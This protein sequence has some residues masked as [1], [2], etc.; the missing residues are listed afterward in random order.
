MRSRALSKNEGAEKDNG[1][2]LVIR[3]GKEA[4]LQART[5]YE[6]LANIICAPSGASYPVQVVHRGI[7]LPGRQ[8]RDKGQRKSGNG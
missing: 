4:R 7:R 8:W 6:S 3:D 5:V 2:I 1:V